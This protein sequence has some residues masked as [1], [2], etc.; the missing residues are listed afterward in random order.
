MRSNGH[1]PLSVA[2]VAQPGRANFISDT[3]SFISTSEKK[4]AAFQ[5]EEPA[6][7]RSNASAVVCEVDTLTAL[8]IGAVCAT[9]GKVG[10]RRS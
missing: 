2:N 6:S 9:C 3:I 5:N 7:D 10:T 1:A 8:V 4:L